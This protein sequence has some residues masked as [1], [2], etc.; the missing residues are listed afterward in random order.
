MIYSSTPLLF[1]PSKI[2]YNNNNSPGAAVPV[3]RE[4]GAALMKIQEL[5]SKF[6]SSDFMIPENSDLETDIDALPY[7][8]PGMTKLNPHIL[9][10]LSEEPKTP[11]P[12]VPEACFL[13]P[14]SG[15]E[16]KKSSPKKTDP[17]IFLYLGKKSMDEVFAGMQD[18]LSNARELNTS[19][20]LMTNAFFS[21]QGLQYLTDTAYQVFNNPIFV[22]NE[23]YKYMALSYGTVAGNELIAREYNDG[24][25]AEQGIRFIRESHL[26]ERALHSEHAFYY[27]NPLFHAGMMAASVNIHE[28]VVG[29]VMLYE[30]NHKFTDNDSVL[31]EHF[32]RLVSMELQKNQFFRQNKDIM[33]SY[34]LAD[35]LDSREINYPSVRER[36]HTM[37]LDLKDDLYILV[38]SAVSYHHATEKLEVIVDELSHIIPGSICA[39][40]EN[41]LVL[42]FSKSREDF[43][44]DS[45]LKALTQ[46]LS[47]NNLQAGMSNFF[48]DLKGIRRFYLQAKKAAELGRHLDEAGPVFY[49]SD[50]YFY[51]IMELCQEKEELRYFIHPAMMKLLYYDQEKHSELL[52]TLHAFLINPGNTARTAEQ[53]HIHKNTLLYRMNKIKELTKCELVNGEELMSLAFSYKL[54][55]YLGML[56]GSAH[57]T[58]Y[59]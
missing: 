24:Y 25:I 35:L 10:F 41:C 3:F 20:Q 26:Q 57:K 52:Q 30:Q 16:E 55:K 7:F 54:M 39:I 15:K 21:D 37:G 33:Y 43:L 2:I 8:T 32:A 28:V 4:K 40:Y 51:H 6:S 18:I 17:H 58:E 9:Y 27:Y 14:A 42:L 5:L 36:L 49:Y 23:S 19:L 29:K 13:C 53:L 44:S 1:K 48:T 47:E 59:V 56:P 12:P 22:V 38:I 45:E 50:T 34:F 31:L 11:L 46:Y